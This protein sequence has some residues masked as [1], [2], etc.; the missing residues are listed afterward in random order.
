MTGAYYALEIADD[1]L[2]GA[3]ADEQNLTDSGLDAMEAAAL[4]AEDPHH[5]AALALAVAR[6]GRRSSGRTLASL[7]RRLLEHGHAEAARAVEIGMDLLPLQPPHRL[8]RAERGYRWT[9][10]GD[11]GAPEV[12]VE[13]PLAAHWH[14]AAA[15][16]PPLRPNLEMPAFLWRRADD[17]QALRHTSEGGVV[18]V[19]FREGLSGAPP[20]LRLT[21]AGFARDAAL[22][23]L[24]RWAEIDGLG[25]MEGR[26]RQAAYE[27]QGRAHAL[28]ADP[29][30]GT[31]AL[32]EFMRRLSRLGRGSPE[33]T[34]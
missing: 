32:F 13:D 15:W 28:P 1:R 27:V 3:I 34:P 18:V 8:E 19:L 25:F 4:E 12:Y 5:A 21:R 14:A 2:L 24:T 11:E 31:E 22:Q 10:P 16:G 26:R 6:A 7:R 17:A 20:A 33:S 23:S 29:E 9:P 30:P